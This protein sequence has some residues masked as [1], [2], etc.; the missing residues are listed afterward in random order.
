MATPGFTSRS[1]RWPQKSG[2]TI[3]EALVTTAVMVT[4][5]LT[6]YMIHDTAQQNHARGLARA[7]VHQDVRVVFERLAQELRSAGYTPS[8]TALNCG[9]PPPGAITALSS[10]PVS[11]T[12]QTDVDGDFCTDQVS[13]TFVPGTNLT[14]PCDQSD[15]ATV[16]R[17]T[18]SVQSWKNGA[19]NPATPTASDVARCITTLAIIYY[20]RSGTATTNPANVARLNI[21][22]TGAEN[23]HI[24]AAPS[25]TLTSDVTLRNF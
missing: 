17:I 14:K 6:M 23:A 1:C 4:V 25:Y 24:T 13:Y 16:G 9:S 20:D 12:F 15:P 18:R 7:A 8:N 11:V 19:W 22:M 21:S 2:F 3:A 10:S 5:L